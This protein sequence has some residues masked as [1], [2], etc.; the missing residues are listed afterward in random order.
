MR[1][2]RVEVCLNNSLYS[3]CSN[4]VYPEYFARQ[5][6]DYVI[7][8]GAS[9]LYTLNFELG[10]RLKINYAHAQYG[11]VVIVLFVQITPS[12]LM[13]LCTTTEALI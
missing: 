9:K 4:T 3:V 1:T 12:F 5:V 10:R 2:G 7:G 8:Y 6:C 13:I 11:V